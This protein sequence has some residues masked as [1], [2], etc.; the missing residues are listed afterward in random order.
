MRRRFFFFWRSTRASGSN[1]GAMMTS[2][3]IS[4]M[5]RASGSVSGRLQIMMPPKGACLSV[6]KA[7]SH[8]TFRSGS[9]P[10]PHGLV[11]FR[12]ATVGSGNSSISCGGGAD[13]QDVIEGEFLAVELLEVLVEIPVERAL[14]VGILAVAQAG[15]DGQREREGAGRLLFLVEVVGDGASRSWRW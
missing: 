1:S 6:A 9:D 2:L 4:L 5:A 13:I 14:L 7:L 3:K 12:I 11:C 10:T 8:A 15:G